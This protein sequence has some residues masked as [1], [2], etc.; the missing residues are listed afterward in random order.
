M[1][2]SRPNMASPENTTYPREIQGS[3]HID[4][5][6][7]TENG[8]DDNL[9]NCSLLNLNTELKTS[10]D[11]NPST[12]VSDPILKQKNKKRDSS[13]LSRSNSQDQNK[14]PHVN[15]N[16]SFKSF[17]KL[18]NNRHSIHNKGPFFSCSNLRR[19]MKPNML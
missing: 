3:N 17:D 10:K 5:P 9:V 7:D 19:T 4:D 12:C 2:A 11:S 13:H 6:M 18:L 15:D 16:G 8:L 14:I 1:T